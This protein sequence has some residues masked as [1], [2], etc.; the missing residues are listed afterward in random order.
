MRTFT[1]VMGTFNFSKRDSIELEVEEHDRGEKYAKRYSAKCVKV[2][3]SVDNHLSIESILFPFCEHLAKKQL[4]YQRDLWKLVYKGFTL[5]L[6]YDGLRTYLGACK[7][8]GFEG[9]DYFDELVASFF[10]KVDKHLENTMKTQFS[11]VYND[12]TLEVW[13]EREKVTNIPLWSGKC[14]ALNF[15]KHQYH[16]LETITGFFQ[17]AVDEYSKPTKIEYKGYELEIT[18]SD[19]Q[20]EGKSDISGGWNKTA[21]TKEGIINL[22]KNRVHWVERE[23]LI[24]TI[25]KFQ[26]EIASKKNELEDYVRKEGYISCDSED[27]GRFYVH[28]DYYN[29]D[30]RIPYDWA[31]IHI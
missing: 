25:K 13:Q 11:V 18:Q 22:F 19:E 27:G 21:S 2:G 8:I 1:L 4:K 6:K 5:E 28:P 30:K 7:E 26:T 9:D 24:S 14:E 20:F 17:N 12:F 23:K 31:I 10:D 29:Q 16:Y 15:E 3:F